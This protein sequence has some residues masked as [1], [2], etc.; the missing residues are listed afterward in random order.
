M[1]K[2][3]SNIFYNNFFP[4]NRRGLSG[5]VVTLIIIG[6]A[7]AAVGIVW[8]TINLVLEEQEGE[9]MSASSNVFSSCESAGYGKIEG[10]Q[11][12]VGTIKYLGGE[13]CCVG[14]IVNLVGGLVSWWKFEGD[15]NDE[16]GGND[17]V[18]YGNTK[19]LMDFDDG[20]ADDKSVYGN[21][22]VITGADCSVDGIDGKGC[23]FDGAGN[24]IYAD[25]VDFTVTKHSIEFWVNV[26][27]LDNYWQDLVGISLGNDLNRFH[28]RRDTNEIVWY[29]IQNGCGTLN[30]GFVPE[31]GQWYHVVGTYDGTNARIYINGDFKKSF[32]CTNMATST[33][34]SIG[35]PSEYFNGTIDEL[36]IYSKALSGEEILEH[37]NAQKAKFTDFEN[38]KVGK[39]LDFDGIDDYAIISG[40]GSLQDITDDGNSFSLSCWFSPNG[41]PQQTYNGYIFYRR[42]YH[43][44]VYHSKSTGELRSTLWFSDNT[45]AE[46]GSGIIPTIGNW[47]HLTMTVDEVVNEFKFYVDGNQVGNTYSIT[48]DLK[49]YGTADWNVIGYSGST[50]VGYGR[51]DEARIYNKA[52]S[53]DEVKVLYELG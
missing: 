49:D 43:E 31:V 50:Y 26:N 24:Y 34:L 44:G 35:G 8:Y 6:I 19:L 2:S 39:A 12:C 42:G 3:K 5:I 30:S 41:L 52:L 23:S 22:G 46:I 47:Y 53:E 37:Y 36:A 28:I 13:K 14:N 51:V 40:S 29:N 11:D 48:K 9:V 4:K 17:G 38:G 27:E 20:T 25:W 7:L 10:S 16:I 33:G 45:P 18:I 15:A 1:N 32:G 21:D